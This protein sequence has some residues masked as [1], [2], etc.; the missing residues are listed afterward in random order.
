MI[1]LV[2]AHPAVTRLGVSG[3]TK[4]LIIVLSILVCGC[5][6]WAVTLGADL[7]SESKPVDKNA[8][9]LVKF[10]ETQTTLTL[11]KNTQT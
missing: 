10:G 3:E 7:R 8:H 9:Q 6:S 4:S 1:R 11:F 5:E 2:Q